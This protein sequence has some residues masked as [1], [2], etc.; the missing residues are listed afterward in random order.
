MNEKII[1]MGG[2]WSDTTAL[3]NFAFTGLQY[4]I[5]HTLEQA[6]TFRTDDPSVWLNEGV[7]RLHAFGDDGDLT[8]RRDEDTFYWRFVGKADAAGGLK[9]AVHPGDLKIDDGERYKALLYGEFDSKRGRWYDNIVGSADLAYPVDQSAARVM[10]YAYA[11]THD[12]ETVAFWTH[13]LDAYILEGQS[14]E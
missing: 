2:K 4:R 14:H 3:E 7:L 5:V 11:V 1:L 10:S 12:D 9:G 8:V 6:T 13:K